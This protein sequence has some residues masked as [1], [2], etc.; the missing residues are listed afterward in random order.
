MDKIV[1]DP[2]E[3]FIQLVYWSMVVGVIIGFCGYLIPKEH[4]D[5]K[6]RLERYHTELDQARSLYN[7]GFTMVTHSSMLSG[8]QKKEIIQSGL[9]LVTFVFRS[10]EC[11][12]LDKVKDAIQ[13]YSH[14]L[15]NAQHS[16]FEGTCKVDYY[17]ALLTPFSQNTSVDSSLVSTETLSSRVEETDRSTSQHGSEAHDVGHVATHAG[18]K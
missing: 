3:P 10:S 13:D 6:H 2:E 1:I 8:L 14:C 18:A 7:K 5:T 9:F 17:Q 16:V 15:Q 4:N 12:D 11:D